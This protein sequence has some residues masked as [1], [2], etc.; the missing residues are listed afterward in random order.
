M[1]KSL[2]LIALALTLPAAAALASETAISAGAE[3]KIRD[4]LTGQGYEVTE[5]EAE[6]SMF[7]AE[8]T[9]DGKAYEFYL[10]D[11]FEV[12]KIEEDSEDD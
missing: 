5:I 6:D 4:L 8:A 1:R 11:Q 12:V 9:K 3:T 2:K 10:N 7:E